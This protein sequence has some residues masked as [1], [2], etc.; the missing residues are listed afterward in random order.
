MNSKEMLRKIKELE[1]KIEDIEYKYENEFYTGTDTRVW[2]KKWVD[3]YVM[4]LT[5]KIDNLKKEL[6]E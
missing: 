4:L 2:N 1:N 3:N 6:G 5:T